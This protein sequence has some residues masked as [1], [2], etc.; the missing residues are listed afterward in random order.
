M[1]HRPQGIQIVRAVEEIGTSAGL[2]ALPLLPSGSVSGL[3]RT[4]RCQSGLRQLASPAHLGITAVPQ[5]MIAATFS[6]ADHFL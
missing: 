6:P 4:R 5:P 3:H 2:A 1:Q